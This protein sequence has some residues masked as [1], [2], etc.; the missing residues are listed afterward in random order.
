MEVKV[1]IHASWNKYSEKF[2]YEV[3][4]INMTEYGYILLE[5][6]VIE[7]DTPEER[8]LR[9]RAADSLAAKLQKMRGEHYKEEQELEKERQELLAL[10]FKQEAV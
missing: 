9:V 6:R 5:E 1:F 7:I 4:N 10:D 3:Y 2:N 8:E